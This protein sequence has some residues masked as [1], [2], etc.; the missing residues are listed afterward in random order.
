MF[1]VQTDFFFPE[2]DTEMQTAGIPIASEADAITHLQKQFAIWGSWATAITP[3][4]LRVITCMP[5]GTF[6]LA[7]D[8]DPLVA[9]GVDGM[10]RGMLCPA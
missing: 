9:G 8:D 1:P 5:D 2:F 7:H 3:S 6:I 10:E 4:E